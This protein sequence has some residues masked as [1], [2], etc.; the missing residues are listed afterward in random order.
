MTTRRFGKKCPTVTERGKKYLL[1]RRLVPGLLGLVVFGGLGIAQEPARVTLRFR[2][3]AILQGGRMR[4]ADIASVETAD[5]TLKAQLE[6]LSLGTSPRVGQTLSLRADGVRLLLRRDRRLLNVS[7]KAVVFEGAPS[8]RIRVESQEIESSALLDPLRRWV[9]SAVVTTFGAERVEV[10]FLTLPP[11]VTVPKGEWTVEPGLKRLPARLPAMLSMPVSVTVKGVPYQNLTLALK[12]R[13]Y[14]T[15]A[16]A[17]RA[18]HRHEELALGDIELRETDLTTLN[19]E[20]AVD[21]ADDLLGWRVSRNVAAGEPLTRQ[22]CESV[23]VIAKGDQITLYL[24]APQMRLTL[25]GEAEQD[26]RPGDVIRCKNLRSGKTIRGVVVGE[27]L[28]RVE[29]PALR[30]SSIGTPSTQKAGT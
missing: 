13:A 17:T 16:V 9:E 19:G 26:G 15:I 10:E 22:K 2:D 18:I 23:P 5:A 7:E 11:K 20:T 14:R 27:R 1:V 4:L 28:V 3:E 21:S 6:G 29:F 25:V 12:L 24:E 8:T 30:V